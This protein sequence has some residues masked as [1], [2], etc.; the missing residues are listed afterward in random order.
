MSAQTGISWTDRTWNPV[1]GCTKVSQGCKHCYAKTLHD[2]RHKAFKAGKLQNIP[3]YAEPFET[4]QLLPDRL[5]DPL[6]WRKPSR[7]FVNSMSDL[8]HES[9]DIQYIASVFA[10]MYLA[11]RHHFQILTKRPGRMRAVLTDPSFYDRVLHEA[12]G[13][14]DSRPHLT[15]VGISDPTRFPA[16]H[17][18][19]GVSVE[20]QEAADE[21]IPLLI[22]T[23]AAVR[24]LSCE[25]LLGSVELDRWLKVCKHWK[26]ADSRAAAPWHPP[27]PLHWYEPQALVWADWRLPIQWVIVGGESGKGARPMHPDWARS[28]RDQCAAAGVAFH[29]KQWGEYREF[30]VG[31]EPQVTFTGTV[32][33]DINAARAL[34][35][36]WLDLEG[37]QFADP[38]NLPYETPCRLLEHVG[39]A[40]AGRE[41]DGRV[42]DEFPAVRP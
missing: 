4:V 18:W 7:V 2:M 10:A 35:P 38:D 3:Q 8:F 23:P 13:F 40:R 14:R 15:M 5:A 31:P 42:W 19:L 24:F 17:V 39:T 27:Y 12:N 28:L 20:N 36:A 11:P 32:T 37:N 1:V 33:A 41:L 16:G 29:F 6:G 22:D 26:S 9:I 21:R 30:D 25:P 34:N